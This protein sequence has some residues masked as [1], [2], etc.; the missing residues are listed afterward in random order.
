MEIIK[1]KTV[2]F[3]G[4]RV[5]MSPN[6]DILDQNLNREVY[7]RLYAILEGFYKEGKETFLSGM[8]IGFDLLASIVVLELK[9]RYPD[10][11]LIAV[12]P[13]MGQE[14]KYSEHDKFIYYEI[15]ER[16]DDVELIWKGSYNKIVYHKR[17]DFLI[18][19]SSQ[20]VAYSN[21]I[22]RGT[23]S[24]VIKAQKRGINVINLYDMLYES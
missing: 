14:A 2:A 13:F 16:C 6:G 9:K 20:V 15:L 4:N 24:T 12:V 11:K 8:A 7:K 5:L 1:E 10:I 18:E 21:G 23:K 3:T 17:N 19:N 22:G